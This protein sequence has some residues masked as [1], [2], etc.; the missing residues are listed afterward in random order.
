MNLP[1]SEALR[2]KT[3]DE[4]VGQE[5]L[6][7]HNGVLRKLLQSGFLPSLLLWGPPGVGKTTIATL[8]A[9]HVD[10]HFERRSAVTS[11][12]EDIRSI[13][14]ESRKRE[15]RTILFLD[16]IH[17][18]H[19]GQQDALLPYIENGEIT[20]I[21]A[22]TENPSFAINNALLSRLRV[23]LLKRLESYHLSILIERA[24]KMLNKTITK[25]AQKFLIEFSNGDAR[26]LFSIL[27]IAVSIANTDEISK[28]VITESAHKSF[29]QYDTHGDEHY[30]TMSAFIKSMRASNVDAALYYLARMVEGGE[31]PLCIARRMIIFAAEDIGI[32]QPTALVVA[33]AVFDG[34]HNIGYPEAQILLAYGTVY[35]AQAKKDRIAYDAYFEAL[36][37]VKRYGNLPIPLNLLNAPTELMKSLGYGKGYEM[38][39]SD[40]LLPEKLQHR[41][42]YR[43]K[44]KTSA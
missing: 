11:S 32:A 3:I 24:I 5:H 29:L 30:N 14:K 28:E 16:E 7:G 44:N 1:L 25:D 39:T 43:D 22:T 41:D 12:L 40:R 6:V 10:A 2:P 18:F 38:Y 26:Q 36:S 17:R 37:D 21:G 34:C 4:V 13:I 35:L 9:Q 15:K 19:K 42:Y 31:D 8:L 20:L 23:F 33:N 27:E